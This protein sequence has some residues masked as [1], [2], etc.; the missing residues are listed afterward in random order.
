MMSHLQE[1]I[2]HADVPTQVAVLT[3]LYMYV[4][5]ACPARLLANMHTVLLLVIAVPYLD[6][7]WRLCCVQ[8]LYNRA[9]VQLGMCA[10]RHGMIKD[11]HDALMDVQSSGRSKELLAQVYTNFQ[12]SWAVCTCMFILICMLYMCIFNTVCYG[13][14]VSLGQLN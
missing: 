5:H 1:G 2:Q 8:I 12:C 9:L 14:V 7:T 4:M 13:F 11:A 10:F 3:S 6:D